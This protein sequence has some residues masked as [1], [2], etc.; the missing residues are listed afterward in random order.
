MKKCNFEYARI[1]NL[2]DLCDPK[3]NSFYLKLK[4]INKKTVKHSIFHHKRNK[5]FT[6]LFE[7]NATIIVAW[8]VNEA[9]QSLAELALKKLENNKFKGN[10]K[11]EIE[12]AYYHPLPRTKDKQKEWLNNIL[13]QINPSNCKNK[14]SK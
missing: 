9:L 2:S 12:W 7:N 5:E 4:N 3:S 8:G 14:S 6:E 13:C 10:K 11:Q 1:L